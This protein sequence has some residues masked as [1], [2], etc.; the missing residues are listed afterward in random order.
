MTSK[1]HPSVLVICRTTKTGAAAGPDCCVVLHSRVAPCLTVL[2]ACFRFMPSIMWPNFFTSITNWG[3]NSTLITY[4]NPILPPPPHVLPI[5]V[6]ARLRHQISP[7]KSRPHPLTRVTAERKC[8]PANEVIVVHT[9]VMMLTRKTIEKC[10]QCE[11]IAVWAHRTIMQLKH[12]IGIQWRADFLS[13]CSR[14][15]MLS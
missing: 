7:S 10:H 1:I 2:H 13:T 15:Y 11:C 12:W 14:F 9:H 6:N 8:Q 3:F 4:L 5:Q